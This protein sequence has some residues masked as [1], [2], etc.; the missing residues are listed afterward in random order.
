[1][2][3]KTIYEVAVSILSVTCLICCSCVAFADVT[4]SVRGIVTDPSG[5]VLA[6]VHVRLTNGATGLRR[7]AITESNG[8]Y[9]F[10]AV[11]VGSGFSL[12]VEASGFETIHQSGITLTVNQQFRDDLSLTM[13]SVSQKVEV[14]TATTQVETTSTQLGNVLVSSA[15]VAMP[16]NGRSYT[17]LLSL[18]PGV[19]PVTSVSGATERSPSGDLNPGILS[20]NGARENGNAFLVNGGDVN[21][22]R[23]NGTSV[24]PTLDAIAE[25][26]ILTNNYDAEYGKFAG[27]IIN[28]VTK[29][30]TNHLH[31]NV[32]E[33]LRNDVL[34]ARNYFVPTRGNFKQNQ[35]GGTVGGP[36]LKDRLFFFGDYQGTRQILGVASGNVI[37]PS[38]SERTGDFSDVSN[39][40]LPSLTGVVN[41]T[42]APGAFASTLTTRLGYTV[43]PGEPYWTQGCNTASQAHEGIC[44]FPGQVIPQAAWSS[45]AAGTLKFIPNATSQSGLPTWS[46]SS[47]KQTLNDDKWGAHI[48][49]SRSQNDTWSFY[50]NFDNASLSNPYYGGDVPGFQGLTRSRSQQ[51][52]IRDSHTFGSS[53]VN[54]LTLNYTRYAV[55]EG[56]PSGEGLG[57]PSSFGFVSGGLGI[58]PT[59]PQYAGLPSVSFT[60]A[61]SASFG[62]S[63][64]IQRQADNTF[65]IAD[66]FSKTA[67]R[68]TLVF[69]TNLEY[70]QINT[71]QNILANGLFQFSGAET[72]NDFADYLVGAPSDF[73]QAS[74][75]LQNVR[76]K[77]LSVFG[78]DSVKLK[79]NLTINYGLRWEA[80]APYHDTRGLMMTFVPGKQSVIF[81]DAPT[82][83]VFP[84]DPGIPPTI[85]PTRWNNFA[86]RFGIAYSPTSSEGLFGTI[87]GGPGKTS[88]RAGGGF[89]YTGFEELI[90]NY[91]LGDAPFGNFYGSP[92]QIYFE[93]PFKSRVGTNDPGQRFPVQ[94]N[95]PGVPGPPV[96]FAPYLPISQSQVWPTTNVLPYMEQFNLTLQRE[97]TNSMVV[98]VGYVGTLGR[99]LIGQRDVNPGN[100]QKCLQ[101]MQLYT[102]SGAPGGC[103][104][105]GEDSIYAINGQTFNGTRPY[106]VTS[107]RYLSQ[108]ELDFGDNPAMLTSA[109]SSYN[110]LQT[111]IER[112]SRTLSFLVGYTYSKSMDDT[113]GFIGP[114]TNPYDPSRSWALSSFNMEHNFVASFTYA[115]PF[116]QLTRSQGGLVRSLADG[117][118]LSG[119][120]RM[121]TGQPVPMSQAGDLSLCGCNQS[122]VDKPNYLGG[123]IHFLNP[124]KT[125]NHQYFSTDQF[126]SE[127]LGTPGN[128]SRAFFPGPGINDWDM[129]LHRVISFKENMNLEL[130]GEFFNIFNHAQFLATNGGTSAGNFS[131]AAFGDVLAARDPRIGQVALKLQF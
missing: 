22:S 80:N 109:A 29:S 35:F 44:V 121:V 47:Q 120:V 75:Q 64:Q 112:R 25:F 103:G 48:D 95:Y 99:H 3:R 33:F 113:S 6:G 43:T 84:N 20:V 42:N 14:S 131:S 32:F 105:F 127:T 89:F 16:L 54:A 4:A 108:G 128:S 63:S 24:I 74:L 97:I 123:T 76:S 106:S 88:I 60:G 21:E 77:Y 126:V 62:V 66:A 12:D 19:T 26:R 68:H 94:I 1:M 72:G 27:G 87:L 119:L 82:G 116:Q 15:I 122:D 81:P 125:V 111:S 17:D 69:G 78:Q 9:E 129:A 39:L 57:A 73:Q 45:A 102:A 56:T 115:L 52:N 101:I 49:L 124:R 13:G 92:T 85:S 59:A 104:P 83:W 37:V 2:A 117:W 79:P 18:Q 36:I 30:G 38:P 46:S 90:A 53:A 110:S 34:D 50:Y 114:Y 67:G 107:G 7:E 118:Q 55:L 11:P 40:G 65:Q 98:T 41:G 51:A 8:S 28:V 10:L 31:G 61:Y 58:Y 23:D 91:E 5:A 71:R 86:P 70:F 100:A 130:R 96:S 93:Q